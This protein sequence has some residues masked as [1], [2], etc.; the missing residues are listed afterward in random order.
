MAVNTN[1]VVRPKDLSNLLGISLVTLWRW[2]QD[3]SQNLPQKVF[4]GK[5]C[6]GW[7][8]FDIK[9][10]LEERKNTKGA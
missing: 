10:W 6:V 5:N 1:V 9:D 7:M 8:Y 3:P 4:Y 2:D